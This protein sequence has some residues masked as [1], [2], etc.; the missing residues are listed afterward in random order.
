[1]ANYTPSNLVLAQARLQQAFKDAELRFNDPVTFKEFVRNSE[2][3]IPSHKELRTRDDRA[4]EAYYNLRTARALG[5]GRSHNHVGVKGDSAALTP[6]FVTSNDKFKTS[7]KQA[8][9][10]VYSFQE[11]LD[12]EMMNAVANFA[13]GSESDATDHLFNNRTTVNNAVAEG[14]FNATNDA[15]EITEST[16]GD[17]AIQ[18]SKSMMHENKYSGNLICFCDT[19]SFNKF[20]FQA[21]QGSGN[22]QNLTFQFGNVRFVH[23]VEMNAKASSLSYTKGF[24]IVVPEG[25]IASLDWIPV[26]NRQGIVTKENMY[27]TIINPVDGLTYAVHTYENREDGT[28]ENGYTQDVATQTEI[29]I[30]IALEHAPLSNAG[31]TTLYAT[32]LV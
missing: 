7:L 31:E 15:Y 32:A 13:E 5:T 17:R 3:M 18:I 9:N 10:N 21:N 4:I 24:W 14:T 2:I 30:D 19:V 29:S 22:S 27:G 8:D 28:A 16:N 1:M 23:S 26:Q 6:G 12:N 20:N 11:M 25:T